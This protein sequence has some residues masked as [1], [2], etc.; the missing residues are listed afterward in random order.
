MLMRRWLTATL[1]VSLSAF[2]L[3]AFAS[4]L[5]LGAV[6][7]VLAPLA[8]VASL[9]GFGSGGDIGKKLLGPFLIYAA[10]FIITGIAS[11]VCLR[12]TAKRFRPS[13]RLASAEE[14][15]QRQASGLATNVW[16]REPYLPILGML[17]SLLVG[18][19]IGVFACSAIVRA[20]WQK[21]NPPNADDIA[22]LSPL[23]YTD[24]DAAELRDRWMPAAERGEAY[25]QFVVG[26]A[27]ANGLMG[28]APNA[29][30]ARDWLK[31]SAAKN[32]VDA[33]LSLIVAARTGSLGDRQH[34][35]NDP[36]FIAHAERQP[37]WRAAA[38]YLMLAGSNQAPN[39]WL[40]K[41]AQGGSR[42]A[43]FRLGRAFEHK[44]NPE[45]RTEPDFPQAAAWYQVAGANLEV[46]RLLQTTE[47]Q[48][49]PSAIVVDARGSSADECD[50]LKRRAAMVDRR[51]Q[52]LHAVDI[53]THDAMAHLTIHADACGDFREV[54]DYF[55]QPFMGG[56]FGRDDAAAIMYYELAA[57]K[58]DVG[59][60]L[61]LAE[62][63]FTK[64]R[65]E[66]WAVIYSYKWSTLAIS[67][68][69]GKDDVASNALRNTA[70]GVYN[71][72]RAALLA[73]AR[74]EAEAAVAILKTQLK[75]T[76]D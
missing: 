74:E 1:W 65:G 21:A 37:G 17:S 56:Q 68:L 42:Y 29:S 15:A 63:S 9:V 71:K 36:D 59:S 18:G 24:R 61:K 33:V 60:M 41:A 39:E 55:A 53:R 46:E 6:A 25:A 57:R 7:I 34:F 35:E 3:T 13:S 51:L 40:R 45:G 22:R 49:V 28:L 52:T 67:T 31:K 30:R 4:V 12:S 5:W 58:G 26:E 47:L 73:P 16:I 75:R 23:P 32:D 70:E 11:A 38:V 48:V 76:S 62:V 54:A 43:A 10:A 64:G 50:R 14:V 72:A 20:G 66:V 27:Y 19:A 44:R 69:A 8:F 2:F